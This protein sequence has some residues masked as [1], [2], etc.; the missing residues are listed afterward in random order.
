MQ[1]KISFNICLIHTHTHTLTSARTRPD[2]KM[3]INLMRANNAKDYKCRARAPRKLPKIKKANLSSRI[4][5]T[6]ASKSESMLCATNERANEQPRTQRGGGNEDKT[7]NKNHDNII[8]I[9]FNAIRKLLYKFSAEP[10]RVTA[11]R[12]IKN[13]NFRANVSSSQNQNEICGFNCVALLCFA[14]RCV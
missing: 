14:L 9:L 7:A 13:M 6:C 12:E 11:C 10:K 1:Y 4:V 8:H 3:G 2:A 5:I